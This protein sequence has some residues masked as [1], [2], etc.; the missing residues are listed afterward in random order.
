MKWA[1]TI[2][3]KISAALLLAAI[4]VLLFVKSMMDNNNVVKL[5]TSFSS[6]YEDRLLV[7]GYIYRMSDHLFRKK[8][9]IDSASTPRYVLQVRPAIDRYNE[10]VRG[11]I[12]AY[13]ITKL[14]EAETKY[15]NDLKKNVG[16]LVEAERMFFERVERGRDGAE[17]KGAIDRHFNLAS[18][19]LDRLSG[20]QISEGKLLNEN[21][22]KIV[23][24]SSILAQ[25][26]I[27]ILIA[28]GLMVMV[29][30]FES[31]SVW[32]RVVSRE[33]LN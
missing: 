18:A 2:R 16:D 12:E 10:A 31:T 23:A 1:Y 19:N 3:R 14:T 24:G 29:L 13:E 33:R 20:I 21:S 27:G 11:I 30:V 28:I 6:V 7:E 32:S 5:G 26:E 25:F 15:F 8:I 22:Q 9:M 4:F 17:E